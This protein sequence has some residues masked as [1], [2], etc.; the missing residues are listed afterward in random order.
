I[1]PDTYTLAP[2][3]FEAKITPRTKAVIP[4]DFAGHP[5]EMERISAIASGRGIKVIEDAAHAIGSRYACGAAV[6]SCKYSDMTIFSFHPVKTVTTGEGGA[7]TT[8][9]P[10]LYERLCLL[11]THG[12]TKSPALMRENHGPWYYEMQELGFNYRLTDMQAALGV[13]QLKKLGAFVQ[14]RREIVGQYNEAFSALPFATV[15]REREG[16]L[17]A[18]HLYVLLIDFARAGKTRRRLFEELAGAGINPQVHYI[19]VHLRPY[20]GRQFGYKAGDFPEAERYYD[21]CI[22]LPLYPG[23][24]PGDVSRVIGTL[25]SL[26][27]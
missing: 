5:A 1:R 4:V 25:E 10:E 14:R 2:D 20:Y 21:R 17:S 16:V 19:P 3:E 7:V 11:R 26:L 9:S 8:N 12:I 18:F 23:M 15:P 24:T 22:S 6:G 27:K 13:S